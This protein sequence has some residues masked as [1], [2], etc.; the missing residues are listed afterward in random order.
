MRPKHHPFAHSV[1]AILRRRRRRECDATASV[2]ETEREKWGENIDGKRGNE[3]EKLR[4]REKE[5]GARMPEDAHIT[6]CDFELL[7]TCAVY[8]TGL[9]D[10]D[11]RRVRNTEELFVRPILLEPSFFF[12]RRQARK[13]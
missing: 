1:P 4:R 12:H 6:T 3:N 13:M 2:N 7:S 9:D 10:K 5:S 8:V 11:L